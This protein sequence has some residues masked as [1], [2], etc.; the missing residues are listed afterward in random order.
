M[1][2]IAK[3][4]GIVM[5]EARSTSF[6]APLS[7]VAEQVFTAA[8]GAGYQ[9]E[10]DGCVSK[11]WE[12]YGVPPLAETGSEAEE[13]EKAKEL[14]IQSA[15]K[16]SN[17]LFVG[18]G[19]MGSPMALAVA[20]AGIQVTGYDI[21]PDAMQAF[22]QAGG[23]VA[24][25]IS[26]ASAAPDVVVLMPSTASQAEAILFGDVQTSGLVATLPKGATVIISSTIAPSSAAKLQ[27]LLDKKGKDI[28][29]VDAPVSGGP[30]RSLAGDLAVFAG[31]S[32]EG[33]KKAA[34]VLQAFSQQAGNVK[35]LHFI[36]ESPVY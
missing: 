18:I 8:L 19:V 15:F 30:S 27:S 34:F 2:I 6:P 22:V 25:D 12:L 4:V 9:K 10:D 32:T 7:S 26:A 36:R 28:H 35:N 13:I 20:K 23:K 21:R 33:L 3:D 14:V 17:V 16:P 11:L 29:L 31:G 1:T 5:D 24:D